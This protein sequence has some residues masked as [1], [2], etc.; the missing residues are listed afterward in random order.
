MCLMD[1]LHLRIGVSCIYKYMEWSP[2]PQLY[3]IINDIMQYVEPAL[4]E[5]DVTQNE[6]S[7]ITGYSSKFGDWFWGS[8]RKQNRN[9]AKFSSMTKESRGLLALAQQALQEQGTTKESRGL[10]A[11]AQQALQEQDTTKESRGLLALA[12]QALQEQ[13]TTK[14][15]RGLLALAQQ[16]LQEQG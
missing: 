11:L 5:D 7:S 2:V 14:E 9:S 3:A 16:A 1:P 15:S 4:A 13:S 12:Q 8:S 6:F 10:L